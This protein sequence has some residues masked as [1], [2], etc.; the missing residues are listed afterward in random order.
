MVRGLVRDGI[1]RV[2]YEGLLERVKGRSREG[3]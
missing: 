3:K 2:K 1:R